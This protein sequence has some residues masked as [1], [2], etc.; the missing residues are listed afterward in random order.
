MNEWKVIKQFDHFIWF[1]NV[2][3]IKSSEM[4]IY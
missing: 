1:L 2:F 4:S 3:I